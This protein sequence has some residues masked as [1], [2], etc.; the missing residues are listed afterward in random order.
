M[1]GQLTI[2]YLAS[3][4]FFIG[5]IIYVYFSYSANIPRFVEEVE[6]ED[7]R[8]K[9]YQLSEILV[10][11]LGEPIDWNNAPSI[12]SIKRIGFSDHNSNKTNLILRSKIDKFEELFDCD[13]RFEEV[14]DRLALEK[15]FSIHVFNVSDNGVR[16]LV[17]ECVSPMFPTTMINATIKRV[18]AIEDMIEGDTEL[19]EL[20]VQ[21]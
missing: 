13:T 18:T 21:M 20:I 11:D 3:F 5:L 19:A 6:K 10:N 17:L 15:P 16:T 2:Q 8:S 9:A 12:D 14:Q 4:I 1:K 7:V